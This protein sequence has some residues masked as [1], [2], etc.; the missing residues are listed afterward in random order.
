[1]D[2]NHVVS[3]FTA[4]FEFFSNFVRCIDEWVILA[5]AEGDLARIEN[6]FLRR[7]LERQSRAMATL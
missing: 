2:P 6:L 1:L 4:K 7:Y 3:S 5:E